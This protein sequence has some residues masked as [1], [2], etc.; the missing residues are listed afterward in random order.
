MHILSEQTK[1]WEIAQQQRDWQK[2]G[3]GVLKTYAETKRDECKKICRDRQHL[4][5]RV[6]GID[7]AGMHTLSA[8][9]QGLSVRRSIGQARR[10]RAA[11]E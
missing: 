7:V 8:N 9:D 11:E 1:T 4:P 10:S 3:A 6:A 2:M 5:S